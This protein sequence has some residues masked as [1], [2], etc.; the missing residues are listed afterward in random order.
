MI[1]KLLSLAIVAAVF[2]LAIGSSDA[3][4]RCRRWGRRCHQSSHCNSGGCN[5]GHCQMSSNQ[6]ACANCNP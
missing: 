4:A 2:T 1:R 3:E 5:T 6:A